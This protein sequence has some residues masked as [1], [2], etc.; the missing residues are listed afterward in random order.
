MRSRFHLN[1]TQLQ[2]SAEGRARSLRPTLRA[3]PSRIAIF[4][5]TLYHWHSV[6]IS[7]TV[8]IANRILTLDLS[9]MLR[10]EFGIRLFP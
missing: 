7:V 4:V 9:A 5:P 1:A 10:R 3:P 2:P 8:Q 6:A